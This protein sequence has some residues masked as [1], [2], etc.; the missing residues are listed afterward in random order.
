LNA[1]NILVKSLKEEGK[2][3]GDIKKD[4]MEARDYLRP[5]KKTY[6]SVVVSLDVKN[7][8]KVSPFPPVWG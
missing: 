5:Q 6:V 3:T 8:S 1:T 7:P 4:K 2:K